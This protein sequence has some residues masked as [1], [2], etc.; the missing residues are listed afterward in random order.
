MKS[1]NYKLM[2]RLAAVFFLVLVGLWLCLV[3]SAAIPNELLKGNMLKSAQT[4]ALSDSFSFEDG[5]KLNAVSDNYA[6]SILLNI[7]YNM[8]KGNPFEA[9]INTRYYDGEE[10]GRHF[11]FYMTIIEDT[12][13][14]TDYTRYFHG[15]AML[16]R[17]FHI[18]TDIGGMRQICFYII[19]F[20]VLITLAVLIYKKYLFVAAALLISLIAVQFQ[21]IRLSLEFMS[22]FAVLFA[23]LP[24]YILLEKKYDNSLI[25]LSLISGTAIAFFDFLTTETVTVLIPLITVL[26]I[27]AKEKRLGTAKETLILVIK[28][29]IAW[30]AAYAMTFLVKWIAAS[31]VTGES[32]FDAALSSVAE[33]I[34]GAAEGYSSP[35]STIFSAV[36]ANLCLPFGASRREEYATAFYGVCITLLLLLAVW[37]ILRTKTQNKDV[38]LIIISLGLLVVLRFFL[39]NN[40]SY[41]HCFF[42]Y[43]ALSALIFALLTALWLNTR[44]FYVKRT[45]HRRKY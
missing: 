34:G 5:Q 14:N 17:L 15:S 24:L 44:L 23:M 10:D 39:L 21:N 6:D 42:T 30:A 27:R 9:S 38:S 8:G 45:K 32:V 2:L 11:G 35:P 3:I 16:V 18:F 7:S 25:Y 13:P 4:F 33:R 29:L 41:L 37:Y 22:A 28:C 43:R 20:F 19:C 31:A 1:V 26:S 12:A 40:H 36:V